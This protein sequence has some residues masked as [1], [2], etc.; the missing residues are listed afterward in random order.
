MTFQKE[1]INTISGTITC[2]KVK[3]KLLKLK[4]RDANDFNQVK[5]MKKYIKELEDGKVDF[6]SICLK[7]LKAEFK[8]CERKKSKEIGRIRDAIN[9]CLEEND[10]EFLAT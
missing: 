9:S 10:S 6:K 5:T 4:S 3:G 1:K 8:T 2:G 7:S